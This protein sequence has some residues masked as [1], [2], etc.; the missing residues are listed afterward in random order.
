VERPE[1]DTLFLGDN[2]DVI[3]RLPDASFQLIYIDPPFNTG[4]QQTRQRIT[5]VRAP[6]GQEGDRGGFAGKRYSSRLLSE[7]SFR[8][9]FDDY[10]LPSFGRS[11][12][13]TSTDRLA[14]FSY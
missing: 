9:Q 13:F 11:A 3:T 14:L 10:H 5:T 7:S 1:V 4:K 12:S 2:L 8:D 6:R